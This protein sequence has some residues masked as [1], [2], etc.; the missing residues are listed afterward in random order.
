M[1]E[2]LDYRVSLHVPSRDVSV[3]R[4]VIAYQ[5]GGGLEAEKTLGSN[6][7]GRRGN[8]RSS[9]YVRS[10]VG[11]SASRTTETLS[12]LLERVR[13]KLSQVIHGGDTFNLELIVG[14]SRN[15][16]L[17][18]AG[19]ESS[20][21]GASKDHREVL[22][23][24]KFRERKGE[25]LDFGDVDLRKSVRLVYSCCRLVISANAWR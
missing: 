12:D 18:G 23:F 11:D 4:L 5:L 2:V 1:Q 9:G 15:S 17:G 21:L 24:R 8:S 7:K 10:R 3:N 22:D 25:I 6:N 20:C 19:E 16:H 13:V 14:I